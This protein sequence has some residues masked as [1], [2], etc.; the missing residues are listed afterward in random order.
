METTLEMDPP[1][2]P[3]LAVSN[4]FYSAPVR[5]VV[6]TGNSPFAGAALPHISPVI[7]LATAACLFVYLFE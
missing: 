1:A 7:L 6:D 4:M 2:V 5:S 3:A